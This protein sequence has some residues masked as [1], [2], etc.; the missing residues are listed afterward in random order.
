MWNYNLSFWNIYYFKYVVFW[1]WIIL[2][3]E[4]IFFWVEFLM[5]DRLICIYKL[6]VY[7]MY[8][9]YINVFFKVDMISELK[10]ECMI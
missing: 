5:I 1:G 9:I 6:N 3:Y 7:F 4:L 8:G 2:G 10:C